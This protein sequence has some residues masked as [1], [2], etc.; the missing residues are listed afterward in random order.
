MIRNYILVAT[1]N[2][3]RHK[4]FSSI[5]IFGL[6]ISITI[7]MAVIMLVADQ[8]VYDRYNTKKDRIYR[9]TSRGVTDTGEER[10]GNVTS[11][12]PMTLRDELLEN[13]TGIEKVVR[14]K[15]GFGNHWMEVEGQNVN[16]PLGGYFADPEVLSVF[17]YKL[18]EGD[19]STAL[20]EPYSL[21]LTKKAAKKLFKE[22]NPV[23]QTIKVGSLGTY[24][25]TGVLKETEQK[26]HIAFEGLAS[27]ATVKSL[28]QGGLFGNEMEDWSNCWNGWTYIVTEPGKSRMEIEDY[29]LQIYK[30]HIA[31]IQDPDAFKAKFSLQPLME[32]TPSNIMNNAIGPS[33]P[34]VVVYFFAGLAC[35]V[36]LTSCFNF[37]N[38]SI[39]RALTRARE[40]GVRKA[41]G[42]ARFQ[43]FTQFLIESVVIAVCALAIAGLLMMVLKPFMLQL[44]F[45]RIFR[46]D[47]QAN[48]I[49]FGIFVVFAIMVG[50]LAGFFPA[51]VLSG[52]QPVKVL[53][54]FNDI[55]LISKTGLRKVLLVAQFTLSLIF[56]LSVIIMYHQLNFFLNKD[57][58]FNMKENI[59]LRLN[60]TSAPALKA[61]LLKY[62]NIKNVA[63]ASHIPASGTTHGNGFKK[64]PEEKEWTNLNIFSVDEDYLDNL[65][66][67]LVAGNFY[68]SDAGESNK[69]HVVINEQAV[70]AL[71]YNS[72][73]D[74]IGQELIR[75][76]DS[77][78]FVIIGVV[79]DYNHGQLM[80]KIEP[81]A[82][83]YQPDH[84][85]LLQVRYS[86]SYL[87]ATKTI[88]KAWT[89]INPTL[90]VD[91]K[92]VEEEIKFFYNTVFGDIVHIVGLIATLAISISCMGL[93]GMATYT[94]ETRMKEVSIRK[95]LGSS[96]HQL[97]ILLSKGFF[98]LLMISVLI[99]VPASW[100]LNNLWLELMANRIN[101]SVSMIGF[102]VLIMLVLGGLT[103]GSQTLR[104]AFAN[105]VDNL[106]NE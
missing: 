51:V 44:N 33:L 25:I 105:P 65:E 9:I 52:F 29:L 24:T 64:Q 63:A 20:I 16:V 89:T 8:M 21:V 12:S 81:L 41:T 27:M 61:E 19:A 56:I 71:H 100:F 53:K 40:I 70:I 60:D 39:A 13:Y 5:N 76:F 72:P 17:E 18:E 6:A 31:T 102:G 67:G 32:I 73:A 97:I 42:A 50:I 22:P 46:W 35:V 75:Q 74:A 103:I 23:G 1:R 87:E 78:R 68:S 55:K 54:G 38:L 93:L 30:K 14:F 47:L 86:G 7:S 104:A 43:I 77:L 84:V 57:Y 85:T 34:W 98:R 49:V 2:L 4:F 37:T 48:Y 96:D 95:V 58:G 91:Y 3:M 62:A 94:V 99:G 26:T 69:S 59:M 10:G 15:R 82:L 83:L 92:G 80:N 66:V 101:V 28:N 90:K 11:T 88:E 45:A 36:M 106:K 79:K